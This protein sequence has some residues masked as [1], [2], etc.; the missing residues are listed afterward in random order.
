MFLLR[1]HNSSARIGLH[2]PAR[3]R[4]TFLTTFFALFFAPREICQNASKTSKNGAKVAPKMGNQTQIPHGNPWGFPWGFNLQ[5]CA[6]QVYNKNPLKI[7]PCL[8]FGGFWPPAVGGRGDPRTK[9]PTNSP[10]ESSR[11]PMGINGSGLHAAGLK[12][13]PP[14]HAH[15]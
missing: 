1:D 15:A 7:H 6:K 12:Q 2:R 11:I 13:E 5:A 14:T 3:S 4:M 9:C 10:W 8:I